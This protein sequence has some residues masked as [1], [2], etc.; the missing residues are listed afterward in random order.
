[1]SQPGNGKPPPK[2]AGTKPTVPAETPI[3]PPP[4]AAAGSGEQP[5]EVASKPTHGSKPT[6]GEEP[7]AKGDKGNKDK[8]TKGKE[9]RQT[10]G[11][12]PPLQRKRVRAED[13]ETTDDH[14]ADLRL[15][16]V[17][18]FTAQT[19]LLNAERVLALCPDPNSQE[20]HH[21]R[22]SGYRLLQD[23]TVLQS[24]ALSN[25]VGTFSEVAAAL[26]A[27]R[28]QAATT[29]GP[30]LTV[31][32]YSVTTPMGS[33]TS[34]STISGPHTPPAPTPIAG[35]ATSPLAPTHTIATAGSPT[36]IS[37]TT[38][39]SS[40]N[41]VTS[42]TT[43]PINRSTGRVAEWRAL[44]SSKLYTA[45]FRTIGD[46]G[47][48]KDILT[49]HFALQERGWVNPAFTDTDTTGQAYLLRLA[50]NPLTPFEGNR[51]VGED[52]LDWIASVSTTLFDIVGMP[53]S[54]AMRH[55]LVCFPRK[56]PARLWVLGL[57]A[58]IPDLTF[59]ELMHVL[60]AE[61]YSETLR[62]QDTT[63]FNALK[64][65]NQTIASFL[66][67][68]NKS[69]AATQA[70]QPDQAK[71]LDVRHRLA[72]DD[73]KAFDRFMA[74]KHTSH[75]PVPFT[76]LIDYLCEK[77]R[78]RAPTATKTTPTVLTI[79]QPTQTSKYSASKLKSASAASTSGKSEKRKMI[80]CDR[81]CKYKQ[82]APGGTCPLEKRYCG[83]CG[84][85]GHN[86]RSPRCANFVAPQQGQHRGKQQGQDNRHKQ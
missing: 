14:V 83:E 53:A 13:E 49:P 67:T 54:S 42:P 22:E 78:H 61:Y 10:A 79:T 86:Y 62:T 84:K 7:K 26:V 55:I 29:L 2:G 39:T 1:M 69:W 74:T 73:Q 50:S 3:V 48:G 28:E 64:Q 25:G 5:P 76:T 45:A 81:G 58:I 44:D 35:S 75:T 17:N 12:S 16:Q 56:S 41:P 71:F 57:I 4:G 72:A 33:P 36:T 82:H 70:H 65:G 63:K 38:S 18:L 23:L 11:T 66:V 30:L 34:T 59:D 24:T 27:A 80:P 20:A 19:A 21:Y 68:Y 40:S 31:I 77:A 46:L 37:T 51:L 43:N 8:G 47:N 85:I 60:V 32:P 9:R 6:T 52:V 15:L